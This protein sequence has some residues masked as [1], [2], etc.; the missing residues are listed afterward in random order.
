MSCLLSARIR[1][2]LVVVAVLGLSACAGNLATRADVYQANKTRIER[3]GAA[4]NPVLVKPMKPQ[5]PPVLIVFASGDGGL[6]G[7][8]KTV[9]Q[10]LADRGAYVAGFS[11][12][13]V[14]HARA[15]EKIDFAK[16]IDALV[17]MTGEAKSKLGLAP[18]TPMIVTGMSRG[19]NMVI[20]AAASNVMRP[21]IMGAVAIALTKEMDNLTLPE[22]ALSLPGV[23]VDDQQRPQ[24]YPAIQRVGDVPLAVIQSTNDSY[25]PSADS[26][27]Q[28]GPD[29]P[30]RRLYEVKSSG[31]NFGGGEDQMLKDLDDALDWILKKK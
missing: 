17:W 14:L 19:A 16:G 8:S 15:Q 31:H 11:S 12:R 1:G 30:T 26:R 20:A 2:C 25:M 24:T 7:L 4:L 21:T 13:E 6:M 9:L 22:S 28:I 27:R 18:D 3:A 29:T 5:G 10:H 23:K